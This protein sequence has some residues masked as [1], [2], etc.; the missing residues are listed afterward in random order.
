[1]YPTLTP[2]HLNFV[3]SRLPKDVIGLMKSGA[4]LGGGFIRATIAGEKVNDIDL[5]GHTQ[6]VLEGWAKD[7]ALSRKGRLH[8]TDN[9]YTVLA[10]PRHPVQF[11]HRWL[12]ATPHDCLAS[13]DFT[14]ASA[15][16]WWDI[17]TEKWVSACHKDFYPDLAS[18]RLVYLAP[19]RNEDAG[20]SILR[21]RK[22]L[23]NGYFIDAASLGRVTARLAMGVDEISS[24]VK[25]EEWLAMVLAGLLREVDPLTIV[26]GM[27][28]VDEHQV[29]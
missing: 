12:F 16:I 23:R 26:D 7:L 27:E 3:L 10:P 13:F 8:A 9:A 21:A 19:M 22:F 28:L 18:K 20:G 25:N 2:L 15:V 14:I 17:A 11:I 6:E 24:V 29:A 5:F 1:M 4:V